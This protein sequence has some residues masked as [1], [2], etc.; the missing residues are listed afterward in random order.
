MRERMLM[1]VRGGKSV[2]SQLAAI[3]IAKAGHDMIEDCNEEVVLAHHCISF[4]ECVIKAEHIEKPRR[5]KGKARHRNS[6]RWG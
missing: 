6:N 2:A 5:G 3:R 1:M 4:D